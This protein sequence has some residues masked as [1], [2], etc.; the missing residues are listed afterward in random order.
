MN[1]QVFVHK[2]VDEVRDFCGTVSILPTRKEQN[3]EF[4]IL[5]S[6]LRQQV[7]ILFANEIHDALIDLVEWKEETE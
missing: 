6:T 5:H 7:N 4:D 3:T 2:L 1:T